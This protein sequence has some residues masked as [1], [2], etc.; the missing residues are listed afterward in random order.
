MA[1]PLGSLK[2]QYSFAV[3]C[4]LATTLII[5]E[6][7]LFHADTW[8]RLPLDHELTRPHSQLPT[9]HLSLL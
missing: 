1:L 9:L 7:D 6:W 4:Q 8:Q 3:L 5:T 2:N